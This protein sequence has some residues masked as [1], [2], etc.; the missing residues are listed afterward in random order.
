MPS[1]CTGSRRDGR[2][3]NCDTRARDERARDKGPPERVN[4][5]ERQITQQREITHERGTKRAKNSYGLS[6]GLHIVVSSTCRVKHR[7]AE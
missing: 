6:T 2:A 3:T 1:A 7:V 5:A 4:P